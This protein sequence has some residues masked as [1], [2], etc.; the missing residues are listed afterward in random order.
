MYVGVPMAGKIGPQDGK[1]SMML[2]L[3]EQDII[4]G[5]EPEELRSLCDSM[6]ISFL[7]LRF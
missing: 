6:E 7:S 1:P 5:L 2:T 3:A 4:P